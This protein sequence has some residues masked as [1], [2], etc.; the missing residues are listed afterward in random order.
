MSF[1]SYNTTGVP[2]GIVPEK[3]RAQEQTVLN[4]EKEK[5]NVSSMTKRNSCE[6]LFVPRQKSNMKSDRFSGPKIP[7]ILKMILYKKQEDSRRNTTTYKT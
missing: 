3:N 2:E 4:Q 1:S 6:R 7:K 5:W